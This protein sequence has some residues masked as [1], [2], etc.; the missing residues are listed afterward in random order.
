MT[1]YAYASLAE[2]VTAL[3]RLSDRLSSAAVGVTVGVKAQR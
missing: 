1:I 2:R 3:D